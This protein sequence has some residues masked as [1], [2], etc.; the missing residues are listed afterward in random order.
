MSV[1]TPGLMG[2]I[3]VGL[4]CSITGCIAIRITIMP[5]ICVL[6]CATTYT[7]EVVEND[8]RGRR[9]G[10]VLGMPEIARL[11]LEKNPDNNMGIAGIRSAPG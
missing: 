1:A 3:T 6:E 2:V 11:I 7:D 10:P 5:A 4:F 9:F 8:R